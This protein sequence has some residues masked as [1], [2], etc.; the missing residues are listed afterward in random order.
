MEVLLNDSIPVKSWNEFLSSNEYATPFQ[1]YEFYR[2]FNSIGNMSAFAVAVL[3]SDCI[4]AL[5]V[6][7]LQKE[8]GFKGYFSRRA[9]IYGGP[10]IYDSNQETLAIL[11]AE[12]LKITKNKSIYV[13]IRNLSDYSE[14]AGIFLQNGYKYIPYLNFHV[15]TV[16]MD[17]MDSLSS[18]SLRREIR[19][20]LRNGVTYKAANNLEEV[21]IFYNILESLYKLKV[22]KPLMPLEFF[23]EFYNKALG[24]FI[25]VWFKGQIIGGVMF[26]IFKNKSVYEFFKCGLDKEYK[27]QY[28]SVMATWAAIEYAIHNNIPLFDFMGAGRPGK[29]YGVRNFKARFG[30]ELTEPGRYLK[31]HSPFLYEIGRQALKIKNILTF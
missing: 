23:T 16:N 20:A 28:P 17:S 4:K 8:P 25:L 10:L 1:S 9:I 11:L 19:I 13:E 2:L 31:I 12:V 27:N 15:S 21:K 14:H 3:D 22:K 7:T 29:E 24:K 6:I 30:G 18:K 5:A 26:V